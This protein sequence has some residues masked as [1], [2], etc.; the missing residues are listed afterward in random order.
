M[1]IMTKITENKQNTLK[2]QL[3]VHFW[4]I[5]RGNDR[6]VSKLSASKCSL[7]FLT[8]GRGFEFDK[9][10]KDIHIITCSIK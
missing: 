10:L 7:R 2:L 4:V 9:H 6:S 5:I 3:V 1:R 8:I